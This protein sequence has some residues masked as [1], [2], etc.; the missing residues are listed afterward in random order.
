MKKVYNRIDI[1]SE[2][3]RRVMSRIVRVIGAVITPFYLLRASMLGAPGIRM[4]VRCAALA[5]KSLFSRRISIS[6]AIS[7]ACFP[8]DSV[9]YF[10]FDILWRWLHDCKPASCYLDISSPRLFFL[11]LLKTHP[12]LDAWLINPDDQDIAKTRESLHAFG[13]EPRCKTLN[14]LIAEANLPAKSFDTITS[15]SVIEHIPEP[16]DLSALE[17][18]WQFLRPGGHLFISV[19]CAAEAFEEYLNF[20]EYGVLRTENDGFVFGQRF[21]DEDLL[22]S[23]IF[24]IL[25]QPNRVKIFGETRLGNSLTNRSQKVRGGSYPFWRESLMM[26]EEYCY[27]EQIREMPGLGVIALE[28]IKALEP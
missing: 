13:L 5:L 2:P 7:L 3:P 16:H 24:R 18:I 25:G 28:F 10:E 14:C 4:H 15:I 6:E 11:L 9:R 27:F 20:N 21:Y 26:G 8:F 17:Q 23:R 12:E 1:G 22:Q 19:P